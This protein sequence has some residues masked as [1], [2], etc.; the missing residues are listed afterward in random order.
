MQ[1]VFYFVFCSI[2]MLVIGINLYTLRPFKP[3]ELENFKVTFVY[4]NQSEIVEIEPY[5]TLEELLLQIGFDKPYDES[6]VNL[7]QVLA[8][9]DVIHIPQVKE[10]PCISINTATSEEL[11]TLPG[12]GPKAAQLIINNRLEQG[13]F[14]TLED[15]MRVKGIGI[16]KF[17]KLKDNI[18]L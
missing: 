8:H 7:N 1:R 4:D 5:A 9:R 10:T 18:C 11:E 2:L 16:K 13:L 3:T 17:E 14:Q 15:L 12:I 6:K